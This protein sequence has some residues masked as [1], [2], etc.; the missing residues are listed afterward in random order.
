M[1]DQQMTTKR[2]LIVLGFLIVLVGV[3]LVIPAKWV[4]VTPPR[5][6]HAPLVLKS[7]ED[8]AALKKDT[9]RNDNPDWKD[10]LLQTTNASTT[11]AAGAYAVTEEDKKRLNDPNN[12]TSSFSKNIYTVSAY[13]EKNGAMTQAEQQ[14]IVSGLITKEAE[15]ITTKKYEITDVKIASTENEAT[16]KAYGNELGRIYKKGIAFKLDLVDLDKIKAYSTSKDPS[17]L[18]SLTIKKNNTKLIIDELLKVS[19]PRSA[20]PY[21]LLIINRLSAYASVLENLTTGETDPVRSMIAFNAYLPAVKALFS[22]LQSMQQYFKL[23][24]ITFSDSEPG[25]IMNSSYT[26]N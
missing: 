17:T 18:A 16:K 12:L 22:S 10:L 5:T 8:L 24:E 7:Y 9:D 25:Y 4:G 13:A 3:S 2:A 14:T 6:R 19:V 11:A 26:M 21:H 20:A 15:K 1:H 23:E